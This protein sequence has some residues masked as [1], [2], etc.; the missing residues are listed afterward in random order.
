MRNERLYTLE[1]IHAHTQKA[2][3]KIEEYKKNIELLECFITQI[4]R[5]EKDRRDVFNNG[6]LNR[7]EKLTK[8]LEDHKNGNILHLKDG[9]GFPDKDKKG[10]LDAQENI[11]LIY[12]AG[13]CYEYFLTDVHHLL[14]LEEE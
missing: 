6:L 13:G 7:I 3:E 5:D 11:D 8:Y 14:D 12:C 4:E 2:K 1:D 10:Y 9:K